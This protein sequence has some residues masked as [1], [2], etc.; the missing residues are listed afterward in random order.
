MFFK[1]RWILQADDHQNWS[2]EREL[3]SRPHPYQGCALPLSYLGQ[4]QMPAN[5]IWSGRRESNPRHQLGR[6]RCYH[7]TTPAHPKKLRGNFFRNWW[8]ELDSNQRRLS[9]QIYSLPPLATRE[10]LHLAPHQATVPQASQPKRARDYAPLL[11]TVNQHIKN[12]VKLEP[13]T[14]VE[15][16]TC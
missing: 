9:Q 6:L 10:S 15:P 4:T 1:L 3:N 7:C 2:P 5:S 14:G 16:V 11:C 12:A 8:R 13:A